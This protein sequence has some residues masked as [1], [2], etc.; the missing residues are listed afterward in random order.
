MTLANGTPVNGRQR[1]SPSI[2]HTPNLSTLR[3]REEARPSPERLEAQMRQLSI[4]REGELQAMAR[5]VE[6]T[7]SNDSGLKNEIQYLK[8][9]YNL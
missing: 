2:L 3:P 1:Q 6:A 8:V 7:R 5:I 9:L 4:Q